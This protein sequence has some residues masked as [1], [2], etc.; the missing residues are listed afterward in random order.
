LDTELDKRPVVIETLIFRRQ[1][2][3]QGI[4]TTGKGGVFIDKLQLQ[5]WNVSF[6]W[7]LLS[8]E[9]WLIG[10]GFGLPLKGADLLQAD[11]LEVPKVMESLRSLRAVGSTSR[12]PL[13]LYNW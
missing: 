7:C 2:Y 4:E 11:K 10:I 1:P 3:F 9:S 13:I 5:I 12:K 6:R 8:K